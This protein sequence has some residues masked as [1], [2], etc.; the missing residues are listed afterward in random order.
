MTAPRIHMSQGVPLSPHHLL[1]YFR[2]FF[3]PK[4]NIPDYT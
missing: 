4:M 1:T 2:E 3:S